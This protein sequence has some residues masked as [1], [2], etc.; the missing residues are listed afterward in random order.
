MVKA[1]AAP[2]LAKLAYVPT[3]AVVSGYLFQNAFPAVNSNFGYAGLI[4]SYTLFDF[5]GREHAVKEARRSS[6]WKKL[7]FNWAKPNSQLTSKSRT[8]SWSVR[9]S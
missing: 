2:S 5:G 1:R 7:P 9:A 6:R 3:V 4:A 8:W